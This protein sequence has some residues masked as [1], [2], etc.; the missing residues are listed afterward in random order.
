[1]QSDGVKVHDIITRELDDKEFKK[2]QNTQ[3][4]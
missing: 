4:Y 1:M 3:W 2:M